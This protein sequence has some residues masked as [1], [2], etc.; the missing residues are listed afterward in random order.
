MI[1]R[2]EAR[3]WKGRVLQLLEYTLEILDQSLSYNNSEKVV[4]TTATQESFACRCLKQDKLS[5]EHNPC[6]PHVKPT[7]QLLCQPSSLFLHNQLLCKKITFQT[8][9]FGLRIFHSTQLIVSLEFTNFLL[10]WISS[11]LLNS[12]ASLGQG[13]LS[14]FQ[15]QVCKMN[16][17]CDFENLEHFRFSQAQCL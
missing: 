10:A 5:F 4:Q 9:V 17:W 12:F 1:G 7:T 16:F 11:T 6:H 3:R 13:F 8:L 14:D 15:Y 2:V